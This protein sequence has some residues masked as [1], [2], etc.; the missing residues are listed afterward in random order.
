MMDNCDPA[1]AAIQAVPHQSSS[2]LTI[3]DFFWKTLLCC[4]VDCIGLAHK[5]SFSLRTALSWADFACGCDH[6]RI[7]SE[8]KFSLFGGEVLILAQA[9]IPPL[10]VFVASPPAK[11]ATSEAAT[12][13]QFLVARSDCINTNGKIG[14]F[15]F[16]RLATTKWGQ[17][18]Q[19]KGRVGP[20]KLWTHHVFTPLTCT[21]AVTI[22]KQSEGVCAEG[23]ADWR[24]EA[25]GPGQW[26]E[27]GLGEAVK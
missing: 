8:Q 10:D 11:C 17:A 27:L 24:I 1:F 13:T 21:Y 6:L 3:Q 4:A 7:T 20:K 23:G 22:G 25:K 12:C 14:A 9:F 16:E 5:K 2:F 26:D 19:Y 18:T 15:R